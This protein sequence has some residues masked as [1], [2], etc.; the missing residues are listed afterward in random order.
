VPRPQSG[1]KPNLAIRW[2]SRVS[3]VHA[4]PS[5]LHWSITS[6]S[7][8]AYAAI[9]SRSSRLGEIALVEML[10]VVNRTTRARDGVAISGKA[11]AKSLALQVGGTGPIGDA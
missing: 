5:A 7:A 10:V 4:T 11:S 1:K 9:P 2:A 8:A 3:T 6:F